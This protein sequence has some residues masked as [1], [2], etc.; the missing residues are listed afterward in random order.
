M[1]QVI[2]GDYVI[3]SLKHKIKQYYYLL[4][5]PLILRINPFSTQPLPLPPH[6]QSCF[7]LLTQ[8]ASCFVLVQFGNLHCPG[9]CIEYWN[10]F[11][12]FT[13]QLVHFNVLICKMR[14]VI[15]FLS[16]S[17]CFS[18]DQIQICVENIK[19][20][21]YFLESLVINVSLCLLSC[22]KL[23]FG[24]LPYIFHILALSFDKKFTGIDDS[25]AIPQVMCLYVH[26]LFTFANT[27]FQP[28][29]LIV[30]FHVW[31]K[32]N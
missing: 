14:K 28:G 26:F 31:Q 5:Y 32:E 30:S 17:Q 27:V 13:E 9:S 16:P 20:Y 19:L 12:L 6:S 24:L 18:E 15:P 10:E 1:F 4:N 22:I 25:I 3:H 29:P 8:S 21:I 11:W 2:L 23:L 7:H